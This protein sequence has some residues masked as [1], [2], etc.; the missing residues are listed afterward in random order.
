MI[1]AAAA[2]V[3]DLGAVTGGLIGGRN[4]PDIFSR[5]P[6]RAGRPPEAEAF[7]RRQ[8]L[9]RRVA[10][11]R[12]RCLCDR[13]RVS[14]GAQDEPGRGCCHAR[15]HLAGTVVCSA[16]S[17]PPPSTLGAQPDAWVPV[18]TASARCRPARRARIA[19]PRE[20]RSVWRARRARRRLRAPA[21]G[22]QAAAF[23]GPRGRA[24]PPALSVGVADALLSR[25]RCVHRTGPRRPPR[26]P[27]S[28][29]VPPDPAPTRHPTPH[30]RHRPDGAGRAARQGHRASKGHRA[31][32][33]IRASG[34][35]A[36]HPVVRAGGGRARRVRLDGL[37]RGRALPP[38]APL[39]WK[40]TQ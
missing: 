35:A 39:G 40:D 6:G 30:P 8:P 10:A 27:S 21:R 32:P 17:S 31:L 2:L 11:P 4:Q 24:H 12:G 3:A 13:V 1:R 29:G 18:P 28:R 38:P 37:R 14:R 33:V 23:P 34:Q 25:Q 5:S 15:G 9:Y 22:H 26:S 19:A 20:V 36:L 7:P 16:R